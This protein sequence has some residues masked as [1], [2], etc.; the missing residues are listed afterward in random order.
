M[1]PVQ[2]VGCGI[3]SKEHPVRA[4]LNPKDVPE[5]VATSKPGP[6]GF[7]AAHCCNA[8]HQDPAHRV[9][10]IKGHFFYAK[11]EAAAVHYA[12]SNSQV[13]GN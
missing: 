1:T 10:P 9:R 5:G 11:D 8:C 4:V 6:N 3:L 13:G 7:V 12:G 2:C